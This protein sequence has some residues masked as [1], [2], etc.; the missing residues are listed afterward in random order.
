[1][2]SEVVEVVEEFLIPRHALWAVLVDPRLYPRLWSGVG[3]CEQVDMVDGH[4]ILSVRIGTPDTGIATVRVQLMVGRK[5]EG[6][7]LLCDELGCFVT[8]GIRSEGAVTRVGVTF[9]GPGRVH[10]GLGR[11]GNAAVVRWTKAGLERVADHA[12]WVPT[13]V[14]CA[15]Q[16]SQLR[17]RAYVARRILA[18]GMLRWRPDLAVRQLAGLA[19]WGCTPTGGYAVAALRAPDRAAI[20]DDWGVCTFVEMHRRGRKLAAALTALGLGPRDTVGLLSRNHLEMV[21]CI[22]AAGRVGVDLVLLHQRLA[23]DRIAAIVENGSV[24]ALFV[25]GDLEPMVHAVNSDVPVYSC[26]GRSGVPGRV[27]VENLIALG[28]RGFGGPLRRG[29]LVVPTSGTGGP[30][31][32]A[33]TPRARGCRAVAALLSRIPLRPTETML[34]AAPL[35]HSWGLAG[36]QVGITLRATVVLPERVGPEDCLRHIAENRVTAMVVVPSLLRGLLDLPFEVLTRYDISSLRTVVSCGAA[37]SGETTLRFMD[38]FGDILYNVYGSAEAALV[39]I[40]DPVDLQISPGTVGRPPRGTTVAVLGPDLRPVPIGAIGRIFVRNHMLFNGYADAPPPEHC[41]GLIDSGDLG[42]MDVAGRL[43]VVGRATDMIVSRGET[44]FARPVEE[45][46]EALPQ[47]REAAVVGV[48]DGDL[49]QR[50]A[51]FVVRWDGA[52]LDPDA[53]RHYIRHRLGRLSVPQDVHFLDTLPRSEIGTV[54]K[55]LLS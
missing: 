2:V 41:A 10:P 37:L 1:M 4:P 27:S 19:W 50:V 23:P 36:L 30:P 3:A 25:D 12:G 11:L 14:L 7:D 17:R 13:S 20:V 44:M 29:R 40:A 9:F 33:W 6:F 32:G 45:A 55:H 28:H 53:V 8:V 52:G 31:K 5:Y 54:L 21:E 46:L 39:S 16:R 34:I 26:D 47:V 49:G 38:T 48:P 24:S 51:A 35:S 43:F 18:T 15:D 22:V 42:F